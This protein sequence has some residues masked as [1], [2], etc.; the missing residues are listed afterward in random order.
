MEEK[1]VPTA[2]PSSNG[3]PRSQKRRRGPETERMYVGTDVRDT[4]VVC[5]RGESVNR[6]PG[7]KLF[8]HEKT[9]LQGRY[10]RAGTARKE[11]TV[12]AQALVQAMEEKYDSRFLD[13]C[14]TAG[15]WYIISRERA[16]EKAK[17]VLRE[18][19]FTS[20]DRQEKRHKYYHP[21]KPRRAATK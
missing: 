5:G 13:Y 20:V 8:H 2:P 11:K 19:S 4:D 1:V 6:H 15:Q 21:K 3:S 9:L 10:L 12:I 14:P 7:H 16:L 18:A 17:Q